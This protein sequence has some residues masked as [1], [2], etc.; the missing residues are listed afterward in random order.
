MLSVV[1]VVW[2]RR[3]PSRQ[4]YG[5][6]GQSGFAFGPVPPT[7]KAK[8]IA[9]REGLDREGR[10]LTTIPARFPCLPATAESHRQI[11]GLRRTVV[12]HHQIL[13]CALGALVERG[14]VGEGRSLQAR[15]PRAPQRPQAE[16]QG[17]SGHNTRWASADPRQDLWCHGLSIADQ[18]DEWVEVVSVGTW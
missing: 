16:R 13:L 8:R 14:E 18:R 12:T 1:R 11:A 17:D 4:A 9:R 15:T 7:P 5:G 10:V 6:D 3:R 2:V